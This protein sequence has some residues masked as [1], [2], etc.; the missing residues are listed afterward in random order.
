M[1][2]I[3]MSSAVVDAMV[4]N[5]AFITVVIIVLLLGHLAAPALE[6]FSNRF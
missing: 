1:A 5:L 3:R 6:P 2:T 4:R